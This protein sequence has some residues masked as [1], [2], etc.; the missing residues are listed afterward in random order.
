MYMF[1]LKP[2]ALGLA[3]AMFWA[4]AAEFGDHLLVVEI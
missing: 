1:P 3:W 4:M 2:L